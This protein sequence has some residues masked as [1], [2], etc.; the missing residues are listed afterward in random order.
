MNEPTNLSI[1]QQFNLRTFSDQVRRMSREQAQEF[2]IK[3]HE[4][5]MLRE[6]M[7]Q[8]FLKHD[9]GLD[10]DPMSI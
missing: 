2:L 7:Y 10:S 6:N 3:L 5:M 9:W 8:S 4:Q 1:E